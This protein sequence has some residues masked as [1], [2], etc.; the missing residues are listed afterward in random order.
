VKRFPDATEIGKMYRFY[1]FR[2]RRMKFFDEA[3]LG[4]ATWVTARVGAAG[5]LRWERTERYV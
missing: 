1:H 4:G 2:P 5:A 3:K